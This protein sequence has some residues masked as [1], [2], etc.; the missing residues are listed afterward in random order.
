MKK[1]HTIISILLFCNFLALI[2]FFENIKVVD[3]LSNI[4]EDIKDSFEILEIPEEIKSFMIGKTIYEN[5]I[6][7]FDDLRYLNIKHFGYDDNYHEG[8]IIIYKD[9]A[10]ETINIFKELC[11]KKF[12]IEKMRLPDYY[13]GIDE[14]SMRDN[15]SSGY[16][17]R[18]ISITK[19][20]YHQLGLAIDINPRN[21]P[22]IIFNTNH[23]EP[24]NA[25]EFLDR[26]KDI[27]GM[28]KENDICVKVFE[29][30]G[31]HWGGYWVGCKDYQHF[32]KVDLLD[33]HTF[34]K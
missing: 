9:V 2:W 16:N 17:D 33:I 26:D 30:Y 32:E 4:K 3:A 18:P 24:L 20:S 8:E 28:I 29:K 12:P 25:R 23:L 1:V 34:R 15:N 10:D 6:L 5:S 21:N 14:F 31:W 13:D 19:R 27:K 7:N 22:F 11:E